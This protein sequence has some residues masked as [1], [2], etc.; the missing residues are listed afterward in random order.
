ME[1]LSIKGEKTANDMKHLSV[2]NIYHILND[3]IKW[4]YAKFIYTQKLKDSRRNLRAYSLTE[5][6]K[7]KYVEQN[8]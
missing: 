2:T 7:N 8:K 5:E 6:G 4:G 3:L 1:D